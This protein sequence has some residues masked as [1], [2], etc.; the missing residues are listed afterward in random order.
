MKLT[1][2]TRHL[3]LTPDTHGEIRRRIYVAFGRIS[4]WIRAVDITLADINGPRGGADKQCRICIRGRGVTGVVVEHVGVD[5]LATVSAAA[6]RAA[7][8]VLR[9]L[10]RRRSFAPVLAL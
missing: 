8:A 9:K 5:T 6:E 3:L 4:P 10:A 2:R 1:I 7:Q